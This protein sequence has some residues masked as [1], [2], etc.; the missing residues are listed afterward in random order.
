MHG[1]CRPVPIRGAQ[2]WRM[3]THV[4]GVVAA[5]A[6]HRADASTR[7]RREAWTWAGSDGSKAGGGQD[8]LGSVAALDVKGLLEGGY[9]ARVQNA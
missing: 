5:T 7:L 6:A 2:G 8:D 3:E 1:A 4:G 9:A